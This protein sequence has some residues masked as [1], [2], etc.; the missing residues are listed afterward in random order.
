MYAS[1][2]LQKY[3]QFIDTFLKLHFAWKFIYAIK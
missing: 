2:A 3:N 1:E